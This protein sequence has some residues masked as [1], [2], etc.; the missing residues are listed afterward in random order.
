MV[1]IS[2]MAAERFAVDTASDL[3]RPDFTKL[4]MLGTVSMVEA[5]WPLTRSV[6][7]GE[8]PLYGTCTASTFAIELNST[9]AR[10]LDAPDPDE[11]NE[12]FP[13]FAR[14]RAISSGTFF[15]GTEELTTSTYGLTASKQMVA[16]SF[17]GS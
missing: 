10:W 16:K 5:T 1:P 13:G 12:Y 4:M 8:L 15:A 3:K 6:T 9:D 17:N 7:D 2:G 14:S 11:E